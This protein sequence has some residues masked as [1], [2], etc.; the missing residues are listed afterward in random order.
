MFGGDT[1]E[2]AG[3]AGAATVV[4]VQE[5]GALIVCPVELVA[6]LTVAVYVVP[7]SSALAGVKVD[8]F[9]VASCATE[10]LT[11]APAADFSAKTTEL[12]VTA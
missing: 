9:V 8:V 11:D 5:Y 6:P 3:A 2:T 10:P 4:N 1:A 7:Y 12:P